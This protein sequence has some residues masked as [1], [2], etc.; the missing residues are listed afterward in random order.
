MKYEY[1]LDPETNNFLPKGS[2]TWPFSPFEQSVIANVPPG[3][4]AYYGYASDGQL[5]LVATAHIMANTW[6]VGDPR[7]PVELVGVESNGI[8]VHVEEIIYVQDQI[9]FLPKVPGQPVTGTPTANE[10][11][12]AKDY[13]SNMPHTN[14]F[15]PK[16]GMMK[17]NEIGYIGIANRRSGHLLFMNGREEVLD[18][19]Y[20]EDTVFDGKNFATFYYPTTSTSPNRVQPLDI[21]Y[22]LFVPAPTLLVTAE[23][24]NTREQR[25]YIWRAE[26]DQRIFKPKQLNF[27]V[28][29]VKELW[30]SITRPGFLLIY[31]TNGVKYA[32]VNV[33]PDL[34]R[35]T[36]YYPLNLDNIP[37]SGQ[38]ILQEIEFVEERL[39]MK[40]TNNNVVKF[41]PGLS[42]KYLEEYLPPTPTAS[43]Q[44]NVVVSATLKRGSHLLTTINRPGE[45]T[46]Y[47]KNNREVLATATNIVRE[48]K[49]ANKVPYP[50]LSAMN[51]MKTGEIGKIWFVPT[52][53]GKRKRSPPPKE[54][55]KQRKS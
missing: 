20:M 5:T 19:L 37:S 4:V 33:V 21:N 9:K 18:K 38:E 32:T 1:L 50:L 52:V 23:T 3:T 54:I 31:I 43:I 45:F 2:A 53:L 48:A 10:W 36:A 41:I 12:T 22:V 30:T 8:G 16:S 42:N 17:L 24:T 7:N 47:G 49:D 11:R 26:L 25:L 6:N 34:Q 55:K 51:I 27:P 39:L 35:A 29:G 40:H 44:S 13:V 14:E 28:S 46:V 15:D